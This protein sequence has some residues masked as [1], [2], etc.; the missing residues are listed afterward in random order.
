MFVAAQV[1]VALLF[2]GFEREARKPLPENRPFHDRLI[3]LFIIG[4]NFGIVLNDPHEIR[5]VAFVLATYP[6][7]VPR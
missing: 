6:L 3:D 1:L 5:E 4:L 2:V 7:L